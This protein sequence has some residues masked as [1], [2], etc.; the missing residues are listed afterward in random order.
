MHKEKEP[1]YSLP[2]KKITHPAETPDSVQ[3][4]DTFQTP[5]YAVDLLIPFIPKN[6]K[7]IW[8]PACGDGRIVQRLTEFG[9]G[10]YPSD[11]RK[12]SG[13]VNNH[14]HNFL[15]QDRPLSH[16][17]SDHDEA[18]IT[19]PPFS[20]KDKFIEKAF[21]YK[22][23]F[24]ML[25]NADYHAKHIE[26]VERGC[27]KIIPKSRIA[28]ITPNVVKRVNA[29]EGSSYK[30]VDDIPSELLYK[31]SSAQFHSMWL[32]WGFELGRTETFV[33]LP[34]KTRKENM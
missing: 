29:G 10:V 8:E 1:E 16:Y 11:I 2:Y 9:Y 24:A 33:D 5:K 14:V 25:I 17:F 26:W 32:T 19:N 34:V 13:W 7:W 21:E 20:I 4:R 6:I 12:S 28:F 23:P 22:V 31:Y 3:I 18:I 27:E 15:L 30:N